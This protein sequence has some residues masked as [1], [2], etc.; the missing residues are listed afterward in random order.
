VGA[1]TGADRKGRMGKF[2]IAN[3]GTL[4]LHKTTAIPIQN[5]KAFNL[6]ALEKET[7]GRALCHYNGN[8]TQASKALG[9]G[10]NTLYDKIRKHGLKF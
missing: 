1:F 6:S 4:F 5:H 3:G 2:E 9:I 7:I 8:I 10:R